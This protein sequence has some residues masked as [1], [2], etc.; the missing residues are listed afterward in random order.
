M[1]VPPDQMKET[2][3]VVVVTPAEVKHT[4]TFQIV[5]GKDIAWRIQT[6]F[7]TDSR[8]ERFVG[9]ADEAK[10]KGAFVLGF[11]VP[12]VFMAPERKSNIL[13]KRPGEIVSFPGDEPPVTWEPVWIIEQG[14]ANRRV[15]FCG[16][17][18]DRCAPS[19]EVLQD[20][21]SVREWKT[22]LWNERKKL[23]GPSRAPLAAL[24]MK[25]KE[26]AEHA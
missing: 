4:R 17:N 5:S 24:W 20:K 8:G 13:G 22:I 9:A 26:V 7:Y 12:A 2:N 25:Y 15:I 23:L 14:R 10:A 18:A 21:K 1:G 19:T 11:N 3:T 16:T 6:E